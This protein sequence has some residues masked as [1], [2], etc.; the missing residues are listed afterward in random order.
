MGLFSSDTEESWKKLREA[1][2][3]TQA[4]GYMTN[5]MNQQVDIPTR[6]TAGMSE[7]EQAGQSILARILSGE[8][9]QDPSTSKYYQGMRS[10]YK[11]ATDE[12]ASA[13][14]HRQQLGGVFHS[15]AAVNQESKFRQGMADQEMSLLGQLYEQERARDNPYTRLAAAGQYG[16]LPRLLEQQGMDS[17]YQSALQNIMFPYQYQAPLAQN[18]MGYYGNPWQSPYSISESPSAFSQVAG[19]AALIGAALLTAGALAPAAAGAGAGAGAAG[20]GAGAGAGGTSLVPGAVSDA[21]LKSDITYIDGGPWATWKWNGTARK[22]FGLTGTSFGLIAQDVET[23]NPRAVKRHSSG[24]RMI[25]Y[26]ML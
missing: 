24:Y 1:A 13:L 16:G 15:G 3:A 22:L 5:L 14:R 11:T 7:N 18:I 23:W 8:S 9:F 17:A 12:G 4:R 25:D 10:Q 6:K 2:P 26:S 20:A 21:R 19:P